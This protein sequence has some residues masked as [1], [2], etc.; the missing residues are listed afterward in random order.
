[1]ASA[2]YCTKKVIDCFDA[3]DGYFMDSF[4]DDDEIAAILTLVI[5][6]K[7]TWEMQY[8]NNLKQIRESLQEYKR[9]ERTFNDD[10]I[11]LS[12]VEL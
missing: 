5:E 10:G 7:E 8:N 6:G 1:M 4:N 3:L 2:N 9:F 12:E 11:L